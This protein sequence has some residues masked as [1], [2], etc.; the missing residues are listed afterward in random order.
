METIN[1]IEQT[2]R[3]LQASGKQIQRL[4][5]GNPNEQGFRFPPSILEKAYAGYFE[6]QEYHPH[7][8]G[9]P[10]A[11]VAISGYYAEAGLTV[12]PEQILI[13][14]GS[15]ESF[16]YLFLMLKKSG[17][18]FLVPRPGYP[19][20]DSIARMAG[21]ELRHY[22]LREDQR[23]RVDLEDLRHKT[24][25]QTRG[26]VIVSPHNPTGAV[27]A[28]EQA[29]SIAEWAN[30]REIPLI[31]DEVFSEFYFGEGEFP[32]VIAASKPKLAFTL[33]GLSKMFALPG[34]KLSW[35]VV[36][37]ESE[38]VL[39]AID[40][41]ETMNDT[42]LSCHYGIQEAL[43]RIFDEGKSFLSQYRSEVNQRRCLAY[44]ILSAN[45]G[46]RLVEPQGGFYMTA[47]LKAAHVG[48]EEAFVIRLMEETGVFVH[49]GYFY[50]LEEEAHFVLS[51]L[52]PEGPLREA[53]VKLVEFVSKGRF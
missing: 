49:P 42:L 23:W 45:P 37:G 40:G 36:S 43:P 9:L 52:T 25:E 13:T 6:R 4:Y 18:H 46:L 32:R 7:P 17:G 48:S 34:L 31:C 20:F 5:L 38:R 22:E 29:Q 27:L 1:A 16:L 14:S 24:D 39:H 8:K 21:V 15:S 51:F 47:R 53:L 35:I 26:I 28:A 19:L 30:A 50:E 41:L 11:R 3:R 2:Y 44:E 33:N 12:D 10:A